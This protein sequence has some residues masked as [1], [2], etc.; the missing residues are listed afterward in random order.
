MSIEQP[1][2][3]N[4]YVNTTQGEGQHHS[5]SMQGTGNTSQLQICQKVERLAQKYNVEVNAINI[6][7]RSCNSTREWQRTARISLHRHGRKTTVRTH[8][9]ALILKDKRIVALVPSQTVSLDLY[10]PLLALVV[11]QIRKW[12]F[13]RQLQRT[14]P[15]TQG[16]H[17]STQVS[18]MAQG[19]SQSQRGRLKTHPRRSC[20][21]RWRINTIAKPQFVN[22]SVF[23]SRNTLKSSRLKG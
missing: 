13:F 8:R 4:S 22:S 3:Q 5:M 11:V 19:Q 7:F 23:G 10:E 20:C 2:S 15:W 18:G 17:P 12:T 14:P 16:P 21:D 6:S 9:M 1:C